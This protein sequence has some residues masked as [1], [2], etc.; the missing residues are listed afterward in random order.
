MMF[1]SACLLSCVY[2]IFPVHRK[3]MPGLKRDRCPENPWRLRRYISD[4]TTFA[5]INTPH[6]G[7]TTQRFAL[8]DE[9]T[10]CP[11]K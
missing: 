3:I 5:N 6:Q 10:L 11:K 9:Q 2:V 1:A 4:N 8:L 7:E